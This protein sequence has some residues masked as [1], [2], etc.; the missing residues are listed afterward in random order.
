[1]INDHIIILSYYRIIIFLYYSPNIA[2]DWG[3]LIAFFCFCPPSLP[4]N[5]PRQIPAIRGPSADIRGPSAA[6]VPRCPGPLFCTGAGLGEGQDPGS[7]REP[8]RGPREPEG[9][10][11]RPEGAPRRPKEPQGAYQRLHSTDCEDFITKTALQ[12][13]LW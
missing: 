3:F 13:L 6:G 10:P 12:R 8:Q 9:A 5:A 2:C 11:R 7:P 4:S 1:M